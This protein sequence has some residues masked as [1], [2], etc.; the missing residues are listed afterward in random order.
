MVPATIKNNLQALTNNHQ[1]CGIVIFNYL[2]ILNTPHVVRS[3]T[4][5]VVSEKLVQ[6]WCVS[7]LHL[8]YQRSQNK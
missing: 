5:F 2:Q 7:Y 4:H 3:I 1:K 8:L 6:Y